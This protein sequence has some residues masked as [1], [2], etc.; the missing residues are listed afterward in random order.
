MNGVQHSC[1]TFQALNGRT[2][3]QYCNLY[4]LNTFIRITLVTS[5]NNE[6]KWRKTTIEKERERDR[7]RDEEEEAV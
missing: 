2:L 1:D 7:E 4:S 5:T 6:R 3:F